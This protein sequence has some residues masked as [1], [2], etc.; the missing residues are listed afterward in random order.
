MSSPYSWRRQIKPNEEGARGEG[1]H[2]Q[3]YW[4][5]YCLGNKGIKTRASRPSIALSR[6]H[7]LHIENGKVQRVA[8]WPQLFHLRDS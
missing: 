5:L 4:V 3:E 2:R 8:C 7:L 1:K 6:S